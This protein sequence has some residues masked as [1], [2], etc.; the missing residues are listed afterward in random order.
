M[1]QTGCHATSATD[2]QS[3]QR[4]IPEGWSLKPRV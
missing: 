2:Y 3:T 1:E 4:I